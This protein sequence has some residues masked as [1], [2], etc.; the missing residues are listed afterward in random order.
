VKATPARVALGLAL[1]LTVVVVL[2]AGV[3][4]GPAEPAA[5]ASRVATRPALP[6]KR[7]E[8]GMPDL[9]L[10]KL[11]RKPAPPVTSDEPSGT[12]GDTEKGSAGE[13]DAVADAF[14]A[15]SW[16]PP[17]PPPRKVEPQAPPLAF[18]YFGKIVEDGKPVV[19]L[20]RNE[21][22]FSVRAGDKLDGQYQVESITESSI[23]LTY[24]PLKL[25]QT[26]QIGSP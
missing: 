23:V 1:L 13:P 18:K 16:L 24:L 9:N 8:A 4:D 12:E 19:F 2:R 15:R 20:S 26:M 22:N 3:D 14:A 21:R 5:S 6:L 25:Q 10:E 17:P 11:L 7:P